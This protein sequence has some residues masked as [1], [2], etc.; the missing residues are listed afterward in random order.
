VRWI[1]GI[2]AALLVL[3]LILIVV[4]LV[5]RPG[6]SLVKEGLRILPDTLR[7][8]RR[9]AADSS[10][11]VGIR[12]RLWLL[13]VYL[14]IPADLVPDFLPVVGYA[15]DVVIVAAVLRSVV[16]RAGFDAV[17]RHCRYR[18]WTAGTLPTRG[19]AV[20]RR[21]RSLEAAKRTYKGA[22]WNPRC[23]A[24]LSAI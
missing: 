18:G 20:G 10:L 1:L 16:R 6:G 13:L 22:S 24:P 7:L 11:S 5:A 23:L 17:Q 14:S 19:C 15:D 2:A 8:L 4:L 21:R 12:C 9:L 3:W